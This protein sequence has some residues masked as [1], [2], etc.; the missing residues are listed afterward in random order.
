MPIF[1]TQ[2]LLVPPLTC[3]FQCEEY[4]IRLPKIH[5]A[6]VQGAK[7]RWQ[8]GR[9]GRRDDQALGLL[10]GESPCEHLRPLNSR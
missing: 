9:P 6:C 3:K 8:E 4:T 1:L 2:L 7:G 10:W 5:R